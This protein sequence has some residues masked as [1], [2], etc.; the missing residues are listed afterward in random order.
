MA[1]FQM[2]SA[3]TVDAVQYQ[4]PNGTDGTGNVDEVKAVHPDAVEQ[5]G[6]APLTGQNALVVGDVSLA[7]SQWL[8]VF[9]DK[10]VLVLDDDD[11]QASGY[12]PADAAAAEWPDNPP[13]DTGTAE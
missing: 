5:D 7:G 9:E 1:K 8:L 11:F 12:T 4:A 13:A 2:S 6:W 10:S 3:H